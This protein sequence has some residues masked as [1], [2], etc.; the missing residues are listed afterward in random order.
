MQDITEVYERAAAGSE[1][2]WQQRRENTDGRRGMTAEMEG[3]TIE[4]LNDGN[5]IVSK[6]ENDIPDGSVLVV[7]ESQEALRFI[8]GRA[9]DLYGP[10]RYLLE[11]Q[12]TSQPEEVY[13]VNMATLMGIKWG[14]DSKV[15][16][17]DP[18][19]GLHVEIGAS[20]EFNLRV[21]D[22]RRLIIKIIG[23]G[24][25]M[26]QNDILEETS[27]GKGYFRAMIMTQV[28]TYLAQTIKACHINIL[29]I[30]EHLLEL[31]E[32]LKDRLNERLS[33]YGLQMPEFFVSRI[34]TPDDDADYQRMR[35]QYAEE[36]LR[37]REEKIRGNVARAASDRMAEE[38]KADVR[39]RKIKAGGDAD[40]YL[41]QE[42]AKAKARKLSGEAGENDWTCSCGKVNH[43]GNFCANCGAKR[44]ENTSEIKAR[45]ETWDCLC[46]ATGQTGNFCTN[47]GRR[48]P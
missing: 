6:Y 9:E 36:Y 22:S 35:K 30:D 43:G 38:A 7:R 41:M 32:A 13:F 3:N 24:Q 10:G 46:G 17:F 14:T 39:V 33:S 2:I 28:K 26:S 12:G 18:A 40:I 29:E 31:S 1:T 48:R 45:P 27:Y 19:S 44:P 37:V 11:A 42:E 34:I 15:R 25:G 4:C 47:C 20:G 8:N 21:T 5:V 16:L 23:T